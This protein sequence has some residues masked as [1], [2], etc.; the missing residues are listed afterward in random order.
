MKGLLHNYL[1]RVDPSVQTIEWHSLL[2]D[3]KKFNTQVLGSKEN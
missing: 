2:L 1:Y 3:L